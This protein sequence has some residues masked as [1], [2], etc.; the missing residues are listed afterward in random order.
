MFDTMKL[1]WSPDYYQTPDFR[2]VDQDGM[3][4]MEEEQGRRQ[5]P[6]LLC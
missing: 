1:S 3:R 2:L 4:E 6:V 5:P